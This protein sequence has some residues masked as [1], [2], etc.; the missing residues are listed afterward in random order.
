MFGFYYLKFVCIL[1]FAICYFPFYDTTKLI[2]KNVLTRD[3]WWGI[4]V[5]K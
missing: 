3:A 5:M 1:S 4:M 2:H